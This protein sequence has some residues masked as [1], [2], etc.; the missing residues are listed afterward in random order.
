MVFLP[1]PV[2]EFLGQRLLVAKFL[3]HMGKVH[4]SHEADLSP[5][6]CDRLFEC[7]EKSVHP[8][9]LRWWCLV[10]HQ[11]MK[12]GDENGD[13]IEV[14]FPAKNILEK[15]SLEFERVLGAMKNFVSEEITAVVALQRADKFP[16]GFHQP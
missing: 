14:P 1:H 9:V 11:M 4:T 6:L 10:H 13:N 7:V 8:W 5:A 3:S 16:V 15:Q 12:R 2:E